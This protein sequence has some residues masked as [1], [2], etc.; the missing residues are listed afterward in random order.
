[1]IPRLSRRLVAGGVL[2]VKLAIKN[3]KY[4]PA[5]TQGRSGIQSRT[6]G[7]QENAIFKK[8]LFLYSHKFLPFV[9]SSRS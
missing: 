1:M 9:S 4:F 3:Q 6:K 8:I 2:I 5:E 7:N